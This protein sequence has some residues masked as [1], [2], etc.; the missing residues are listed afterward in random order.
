MNKNHIIIVY[1][2]FSM[3]CTLVSAQETETKIKLYAIYTPSHQILL[4]KWFLP[5]IQDDYEIILEYHDQ[6]CP[7]GSFMHSGWTKTTRRKV[8][9]IIQAVKDNWGKIFIYSD[10]DIQFFGKTKDIILDLIQDKDIIIQ[11]NNPTG[12]ACSGFFVCKGNEQTLKLWQMAKEYMKQSGKSDQ[13]ALNY[14]LANSAY[15]KWDLL[16]VE[17]FNGGTLTGKLWKPGLKLPIPNNIVI[18]HANWT[19]G[20]KN[21]I[22]QLTYVRK[23]VDSRQYST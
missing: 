1:F 5:S 2:F 8:D 9:M 15:I 16:P 19:I 13:R 23:V 21:K 3:L 18:H 17:F 7:S 14:A 20:I 4:D 12:T 22:A 10:V 6:E 11:R